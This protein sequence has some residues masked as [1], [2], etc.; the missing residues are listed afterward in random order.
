MAA[1]NINRKRL[2]A[3]AALGAAAMLLLVSSALLAPPPAGP[4]PGPGGGGGC[5]SPEAQQAVVLA[6][7]WE[8]GFTGEQLRV[9]G[10][11]DLSLP[12]VQDRGNGSFSEKPV[13]DKE[14]LVAF[15]NSDSPAAS[16]ARDRVLSSI[17]ESGHERAM[18]GSGWT[19]VQF[20]SP[21]TFVGNTT[22]V[23]G[24]AVDA[25]HRES[26]NGDI[27]WFHVDMDCNIQVNA[28]LRG[29]CGNPQTAFPVP[30]GETPPGSV[31]PGSVPP[32][33]IPPTTAPPTTGTVPPVTTTRPPCNKDYERC[34]PEGVRTPVTPETTRPPATTIPAPAPTTPAPT[35]PATT[36]VPTVPDNPRCPGGNCPTH[37]TPPPTV[38]PPATLPPTTVAPS[39]TV[40]PPPSG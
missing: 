35:T 13:T 29:P 26:L 19:G 23:D 21:I 12:G 25:G 17:P 8:L 4:N 16:A 30:P 37:P 34:I 2:S 1:L 11:F 14:S 6:Q 15:L 36:V 27:W 39:T 33:T 28:T 22:Y 9:E 40:A 5:A 24:Q 3:A 20:V 18:D 38:A 32:G 10:D 7:L 31:P